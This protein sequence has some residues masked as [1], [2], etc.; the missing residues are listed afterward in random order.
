MHLAYHVARCLAFKFELATSGGDVTPVRVHL[1][2]AEQPALIPQSSPSPCFRATLF[3]N[4]HHSTAP[5]PPCRR[6]SKSSPEVSPMC[7]PVLLEHLLPALPLKD[8]TSLSA[9]NRYF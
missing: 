4:T 7:Q 3:T 5:T 8:L 1:L 2:V 9:V 6:P